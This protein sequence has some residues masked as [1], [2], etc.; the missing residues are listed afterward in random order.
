MKT[1]F[2]RLL[3]MFMGLSLALCLLAGLACLSP[4]VRAQPAPLVY[5]SL[6]QVT[7]TNDEYG[8][9]GA[10]CS[11]REAI[12]AANTDTAFGGCGAGSGDDTINLPAG[13]YTL[14]LAGADEDNNATGDLDVRSNI[15]ISGA[16][17]SSTI[18][19]GNQLDRVLYIHQG[20]VVELNDVTITNGRSPDGADGPPG[21]GASYGEAGGGIINEGGILTIRRC[22]ISYNRTGDGGRGG[23][24]GGDGW[25]GGGGGGGLGGG[26]ASGNGALTIENSVL[27][28]NVT[29]DGGDGGNGGS[30]GDGENGGR[31]GAIYASDSPLIIRNS[32]IGDNRTGAGGVG[33]DGTSGPYGG[34]GGSGGDGGSGGAIYF[35]N[36]NL[37]DGTLLIEDS[38]IANNVTGN[39]NDGG[40]GGPGGIDGFFGI[41][42]RG[43][44]LLIYTNGDV[45]TTVTITNSAID[46]NQSGNAGSGGGMY[47]TD[48]FSTGAIT[49]T[50]QD[51]TVSN[52]STGDGVADWFIGQSGGLGGGIYH[53]SGTL[54]IQGSVISGNSTGDGLNG[55]D[56]GGIW[57][58]NPLIIRN[59]EISNNHTGNS[60]DQFRGGNGAGI[61]KR[62]SGLII[63]DSTISNNTTGSG[64]HSST[65]GGL[66]NTVSPVTIRNSVFENNRVDNG[67]L[68]GSG[69]AVAVLSG[70]LIVEHSR[71]SNNHAGGYGG[72]LMTGGDTQTLTSVTID[73]NSAHSGGGIDN[74][75]TLTVTNSTLSDNSSADRGGGIAN[76]GTL[77]VTN[78]TISGN[79][80]NT[81]GGISEDGSSAITVANSI[82]AQQ[83]SG[84]DCSGAINSNGYN[85]ESSTSCGFNQTGDQQNVTAF[86]LGL[87]AL[88]DNGGST[89]TMALATGSV[90]LDQIPPAACIVSTDQRGVFR[91]QGDK[92]DVGAFESTGPPPM[93]IHAGWNLISF[94]VT[95]DAGNAVTDVL[96]PIMSDLIVAQGFDGG[97]ESYYQ[98]TLHT[99][100]AEHGYWLKVGSD[101]TLRITGTKVAT[102]TLIPLAAGWNLIGYLPD[103]PKPLGTALASINGKYTAVLSFDQGAESWYAVL[104][105]TMNTLTAMHPKR[106]YW[107]YMTQAANLKYP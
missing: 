63:E 82:V 76:D 7:T 30:G 74:Y 99:M 95:P 42:G 86:A 103:T 78:S 10:G 22:E 36:W 15:V 64:P 66:Y 35:S 32:T 21:G 69:G 41:G 28:H 49:I 68:L 62:D 65:G 88:A 19:D 46:W 101:T 14:T 18:I 91:P 2:R 90:A 51:S 37:A 29:G 105:S 26:I 80:A 47:A 75:G 23:D 5:S 73:G 40:T 27:S 16:G 48:I 3:I 9:A 84:G 107:I 87:L 85:I 25:S 57:S 53:Q 106:G 52:N 31:G 67:S 20:A 4:S 17:A 93:Y 94:N 61:Y 39:G 45:N 24:L 34:N 11:L 81:G 6:I 12:Q 33:G 96:A 54:I 38:T 1:Q 97:A 100:D 98:N 58:R 50:L 8:A 104:P 92:C 60:N 59:S 72:G 89:R 70:D 44:G 56:G 102:N 43:G 55:G 83:A 79:S 71:F 77:T 13:T